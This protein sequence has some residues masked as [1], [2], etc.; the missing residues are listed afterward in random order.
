MKT[1]T[2]L[3]CRHNEENKQ[4]LNPWNSHLNGSVGAGGIRLP[5][6]LEVPWSFKKKKNQIRSD[7]SHVVKGRPLPPAMRHQHHQEIVRNSGS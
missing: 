6:Y 3:P 5:P 2:C 1:Y 7:N 4:D